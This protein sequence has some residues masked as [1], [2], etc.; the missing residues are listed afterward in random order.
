MRGLLLR[1]LAG[2]MGG[3]VLFLLTNMA[4][5]M[6]AAK[7]LNAD[8]FATWGMYQMVIALVDGI[9]QG[10]IHNGL[11]R[12]I[13]QHS[14]DEGRITGSALLI[15]LVFIVSIYP[16]LLLISGPMAAFFRM[17]MLIHLMP[18]SILTLLGLGSLQTFFNLLFAKK[19]ENIYF[20]TTLAFLI[21]SFIG[22]G[23]L[24][25]LEKVGI[26][27]LLLLQ[28]FGA[29]LVLS[30]GLI[31]KA[32]IKFQL[33]DK[34]WINDLLHFGKH[35]AGTNALSLLF[36]KADLLM[37]AFFLGS[38]EVAIFLVVGKVLQ[39]V[40]LPLSAISPWIYPRIAVAYRSNPAIRLNLEYSRSILILFVLL[41]PSVVVTLLFA[42]TLVQWISSA[43]Y[44]E[45]VPLVMI[46][47]LASFSKPWGRVFGMSLDA[48]GM[49]KVNFQMLALSLLINVVLNASLI[50]VWGLTG[51]VIATGSSIVITV[52]IGQMRLRNYLPLEGFGKRFK[53]LSESVFNHLN[54]RNH[55]FNFR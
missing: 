46:L 27:S 34:K 37:I 39:Y 47:V 29:L 12:S 40:E 36:Q 18:Y 32:W 7:N 55:E 6:M 21:I 53:L 2:A 13:L 44:S 11:T 1:Q 43:E 50:P 24:I 8:A 48:A 31:Q 33:P 10:L 23:A 19:K 15:H 52:V 41:M 4:F 22:M 38:E 30:V 28:S 49:P 54:K 26:I 9:R 16:L 35:V 17:P 20:Q 42:D 45:A 51:A 14:E 25:A 3:Q 5:F